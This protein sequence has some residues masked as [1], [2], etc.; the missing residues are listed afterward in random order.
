MLRDVPANQASSEYHV[1]PSCTCLRAQRAGHVILFST[2]IGAHSRSEGLPAVFVSF[3]PFSFGFTAPLQP[4]GTHSFFSFCWNS[5]KHMCTMREASQECPPP[6]SFVHLEKSEGRG[7]LLSLAG[8]RS[9]REH[10][11][12][13]CRKPPF[14]ATLPFLQAGVAERANNLNCNCLIANCAP[15]TRIKLL[16]F[17]TYYRPKSVFRVVWGTH[18]DAYICPTVC[19][20]P[21]DARVHVRSKD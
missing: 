11:F 14:T 17:V 5:P 12:G 20:L 6:P 21:M 18:L 7:F 15:S 2:A 1:T 19:P 8:A 3:V 13:I 10:V 9:A 16:Q 4:A